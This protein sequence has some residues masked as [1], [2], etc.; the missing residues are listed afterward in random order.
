MSTHFDYQPPSE[1]PCA[2]VR[3][4]HRR[5][6]NT[7]AAARQ[8]ARDGHRPLPES[9]PL[10]I[11]TTTRL[12]ELRCKHCLDYLKKAPALWNKLRAAD[13]A[14]GGAVTPTAELAAQAAE[15][16][17]HRARRS[18]ARSERRK[19]NA[20]ATELEARTTKRA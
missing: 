20:Q 12:S 7:E 8:T 1:H 4:E 17:A 18:A 10:V 13:L 5:W 15:Q 16:E 6:Q 19:L 2:G 11:Q 3:I 9:K 14:A